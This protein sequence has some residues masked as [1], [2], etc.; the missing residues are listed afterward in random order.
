MVN[1]L[2]F[3]TLVTCQYSL[4]KQS[5]SRSKQSDQGLP[6]TS[7]PDSQHFINSEQKEKSN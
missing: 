2:K 3:Q 6:L 5:R 1:V 7:S 4:D